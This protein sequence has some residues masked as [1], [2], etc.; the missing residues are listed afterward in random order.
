MQRG[1]SL[2]KG[3]VNIT[4]IS[5]DSLSQELENNEDLSVQPLTLNDAWEVAFG[6]VMLAQQNTVAQMLANADTLVRRLRAI[7]NSSTHISDKTRTGLD[8]MNM[9]E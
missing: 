5:T 1:R 3:E 4:R 9:N 7:N 2:E 6:D 8:D